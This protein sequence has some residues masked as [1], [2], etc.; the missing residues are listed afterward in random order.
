[1]SLRPHSNPHPYQ[2]SIFEPSTFVGGHNF[3]FFTQDGTGGSAV[4]WITT[5]SSNV[6]SI[7][8]LPDESK[9]RLIAWSAISLLHGEQLLAACRSIVENYPWFLAAGVPVSIPH[10]AE[11]I[12]AKTGRLVERPPISID[13]D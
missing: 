6:T 10:E 8:D 12:K 5:I 3:Q 4:Q 7:D 9:Y 11:R 13:E 1:M 2:A